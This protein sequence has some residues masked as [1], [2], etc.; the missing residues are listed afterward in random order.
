MRM[1]KMKQRQ[2]SQE[3]EEL[4]QLQ[5]LLKQ[6]ISGLIRENER[7]KYQQYWL[8]Q[9]EILTRIQDINEEN[10]QLKYN[11]VEQRLI[12][13][14]AVEKLS[15]NETQINTQKQLSRAENMEHIKNYVDDPEVQEFFFA[16]I[17]QLFQQVC[18]RRLIELRG[19]FYV[20][21]F[22][23]TKQCQ[24]CQYFHFAPNKNN[25]NNE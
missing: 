8:Q 3:S 6:Q 9:N 17:E 22:V 14:Q 15:N 21:N 24:A 23:E 18:G 11:I 19:L 4:S 20:I 16:L 1:R 5:E 25:A 7:I 10:Y 13:K 2:S 12:N